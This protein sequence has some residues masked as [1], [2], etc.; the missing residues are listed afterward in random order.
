VDQVQQL[1]CELFQKALEKVHG[2]RRTL[3][4]TVRVLFDRWV[5]TSWSQLLEAIAFPERWAIVPINS[6]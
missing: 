1:S 4:E 6:S 2:T 3:W 5:F